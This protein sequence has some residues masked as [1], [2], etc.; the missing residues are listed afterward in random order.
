MDSE[1]RDGIRRRD[2]INLKDTGSEARVINWIEN[3]QGVT[4]FLVRLVDSGHERF[5]KRGNLV[6]RERLKAAG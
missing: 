2:M 1:T 3:R 4:F 5:A 6:T